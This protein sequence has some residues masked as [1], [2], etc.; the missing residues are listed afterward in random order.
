MPTT[1]TGPFLPIGTHA[2]VILTVRLPNGQGQS[3]V[4][5]QGAFIRDWEGYE[6]GQPPYKITLDLTA[7]EAGVLED[8]MNRGAV[9][10]SFRRLDEP[11]STMRKV[12]ELIFG[13]R[14]EVVTGP[15]IFEDATGN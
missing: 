12:R 1:M 10:F 4:I 11:K 14:A 2:N 9:S 7:A 13:E 15:E 6:H 8:A 5:I 3:R